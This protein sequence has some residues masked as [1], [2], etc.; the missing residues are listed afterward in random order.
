ML[1]TG[2]GVA[3][4]K[5]WPAIEKCLLKFSIIVDLSVVTVFPTLSALGSWAAGRRCSYSPWT[6]QW[7]RTFWSLRYRMHVS[8]EKASLCFPNCLCIL[9]PNFSEKLHIAG[10]IRC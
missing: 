7:P 4:W 1:L 5:A 2:V 10:A 3:W 8:V 9:V 6:L